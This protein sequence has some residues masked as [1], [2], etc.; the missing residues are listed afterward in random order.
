MSA[1]AKWTLPR[2]AGRDTVRNLYFFAGPSLTIDGHAQK[3]HARIEVKATIDIEI[4]AGDGECEI[5]LLQGRPIAEPVA[6]YG[7]F[8]MN[9]RAEIE[10]AFADYRRTQFGGWPWPVNDPVHP[11]GE[12]RFAKHADG[13]VERRDR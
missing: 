3:S 1:G 6:Q 9:T 2:A 10:Q 4:R 8:V 11:R 5:L 7:P 13:K 12:G